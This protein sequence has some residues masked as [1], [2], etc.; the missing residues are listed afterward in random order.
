MI[1]IR[2]AFGRFASVRGLRV[3][4]GC[5][6]SHWAYG[7]Q[8]I[9]LLVAFGHDI[10]EDWLQEKLVREGSLDALTPLRDLATTEE[11]V[12]K[13]VPERLLARLQTGRQRPSRD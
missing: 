12:N 11:P 5:E 6:N 8:A 9:D 13:E 4:L 7:Q 1:Q 3:R 10:N 2:T